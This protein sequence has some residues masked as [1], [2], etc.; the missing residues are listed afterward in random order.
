MFPWRERRATSLDWEL[1]KK[2]SWPGCGRRSVRGG[3]TP[4]PL[5][6]ETLRRHSEVRASQN[7]TAPS[8]EQLTTN[9]PSLEYRAL[10]TKDSCPLNSFRS[11]RDFRPCILIDEGRE[12]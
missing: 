2:A 10:F 12:S 4:S 1:T 11:L 3:G 8:L 5:N 7:F 9:F 6:T